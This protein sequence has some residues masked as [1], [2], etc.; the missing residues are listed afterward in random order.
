MLP[1]RRVASLIVS[2]TLD[3]CV[4]IHV[5]CGIRA[6]S[7]GSGLGDTPKCFWRSTEARLGHV[8]GHKVREKP[9]PLSNQ[10]TTTTPHHRGEVVP[11]YRGC[12][13]GEPGTY[14]YSSL[15]IN[16]VRNA[17]RNKCSFSTEFILM[18]SIVGCHFLPS[19]TINRINRH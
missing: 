5:W 12:G 17:S 15:C 16:Y 18:C 1:L 2:C 11:A 8:I 19:T 7:K 14:N 9:L 3:H 4:L 10:W 6:L 13:G